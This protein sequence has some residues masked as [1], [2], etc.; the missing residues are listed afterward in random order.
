MN[1]PG[2]GPPGVGAQPKLAL[3]LPIKLRKYNVYRDHI[4]IEAI[5]TGRVSEFVSPAAKP[6][7]TPSPEMVGRKPPEILYQVRTGNIRNLMPDDRAGTP[8]VPQT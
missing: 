5:D 8:A 4:R 6:A 2:P 3:Y 1:E 7:I